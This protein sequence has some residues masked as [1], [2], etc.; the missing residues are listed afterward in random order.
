MRLARLPEETARIVLRLGNAYADSR[1]DFAGRRGW[2]GKNIE[3][4]AAEVYAIVIPIEMKA[5]GQ[6]ARAAKAG[7]RTD[8]D[9]AGNSFR[10]DD[11]IEHPMNAV[12]EIH[13]CVARRTEDNFCAWG[14]PAEGMGG[15][16]VFREVCFDFG[17]AIFG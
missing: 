9:T 14:N 4:H 5:L 8:E 15:G 10:L 7:S 13:V 11:K 12:V 2:G 17:D 1:A 3:T 6:K 16:I